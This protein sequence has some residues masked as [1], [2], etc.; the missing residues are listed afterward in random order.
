LAGISD[1]GL[2]GTVSRLQIGRLG[3]FGT[4]TMLDRNT[5]KRLIELALFDVQAWQYLIVQ[6]ERSE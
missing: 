4:K 1:L 2:R 3:L 6:A 5:I